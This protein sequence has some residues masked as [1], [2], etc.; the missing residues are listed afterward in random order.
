[1]KV[2]ESIKYRLLANS[3]TMQW[4]NCTFRPKNWWVRYKTKE[5]LKALSTNNA[6]I[7]LFI[8]CGRTRLDRTWLHADICHGEVYVNALKPLPF[9]ANSVNFIFSEHFIEHLP[10]EKMRFFWK[11]CFRILRPGGWMRHSTP[12]LDFYIK[13][14]EGKIEGVTL[15]DFYN[16]IRHIRKETPHRCIFINEVLQMWGH[17]FNYSEDYLTTIWQDS[18]FINL[19]RAEYGVSSVTD[20]SNLEQHGTEAWYRNQATLIME[21]QK[22]AE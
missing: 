7:K 4:L 1:M 8:G 21:A 9:Q 17:Q 20:L 15:D 6:Y 14:Y 11:E 5:R 18:N 2:P 12:D 19:R 10:E 13:L 3:P 22:P 16:R